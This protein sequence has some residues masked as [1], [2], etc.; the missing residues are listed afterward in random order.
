DA[1]KDIVDRAEFV[2]NGMLV[3]K[4][5]YSY[6][7]TFSEYYA[8]SDGV[9][10][11]YMRQF[12]NENGTVAYTEYIDGETN[13]YAFPDRKFYNR[14]AFVAYFIECL[15]LTS[16]DILILDRATDVGQAIIQNAGDSK[17]G[18]VVHAEHFSV[19]ATDDDHVL[20]N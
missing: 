15:E 18:V 10:K 7:R 9:A 12:Y 14:E 13:L 2:I 6:V 11:V 19:H 1:D 4:D 20:W 17:I 8:P 3:R 5:Y 16:E